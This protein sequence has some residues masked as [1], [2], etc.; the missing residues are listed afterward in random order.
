MG[1]TKDEILKTLKAGQQS[2]ASLKADPVVLGELC[3]DGLINIYNGLA[4]LSGAGAA[5]TPDQVATVQAELLVAAGACCG[6]G[7]VEELEDEERFCEATGP[8]H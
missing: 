1:H 7:G 3:R 4:W 6:A 5:A 2:I 8:T